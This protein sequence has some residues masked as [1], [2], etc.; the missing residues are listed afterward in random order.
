MIPIKTIN[1]SSLLIIIS[2]ILLINTQS[3]NHENDISLKIDELNSLTTILDDLNNNKG[4]FYGSFNDGTDDRY[5]IS[6]LENQYTEN[7]GIKYPQ[8]QISLLLYL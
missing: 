7:A 3:S 2:Q 4:G 8:F 6:L 5:Q 1:Y